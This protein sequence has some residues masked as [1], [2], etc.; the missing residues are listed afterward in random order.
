MKI[1][2]V[3]VCLKLK[4]IKPDLKII[5]SWKDVWQVDHLMSSPL[6]WHNDAPDFLHLRVIR[7]T[8]TKK[9]TRNLQKN[10]KKF[11]K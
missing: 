10:N 4:V 5:V 9:V 6:R 3:D 11:V 1:S 7:W 8:D 2:N